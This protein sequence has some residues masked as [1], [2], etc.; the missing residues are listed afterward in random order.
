MHDRLRT[1]QRIEKAGDIVAPTRKLALIMPTTSWSGTFEPCARRVLELLDG[2]RCDAEFV[3]VLDGEASPPPAWLA[4]PDV[5]VVSTGARSGPA[6]ARN[7]AAASTWAELLFFVDAD[8][9]LAD[10]SLE[11]VAA[12]FRDDDGLVGL[13]GAY[14][15]EPAAPGAASQFRNLLH[16]HTH[17]VHPG[18][19]ETFWSGCGAMRA[20]EFRAAGGFDGGFRYP[21]VEDIELGT[22]INAAGGRIELEPRLRCKHHKA[23]SVRSMV[24]TD[25]SHR[26]VPWTQMMLKRRSM[27]ACLAIDWRNRAS[28]I[29]SVAALVAAAAAFAF[30][31]LWA[32]VAACLTAVFALNLRFYRLCRRKRGMAFA[33]QAFALHLLFF[34][35]S[36]ATF[37]A[38]ILAWL[39]TPNAARAPAVVPEAAAVPAKLP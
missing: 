21:S 5:R 23:W 28:G 1:I 34:V 4:R 6:V 16:H 13:F 36:S 7:H 8:V 19:A 14:D 31:W 33:A 20:V 9:E 37:A 26:A 39:V 22:R 12:R 29:L 3:V 2:S 27:P 17:V 18:R 30:P 32:A 25:V 11:L 10:D 15:D 35:Y 38:V 24:V